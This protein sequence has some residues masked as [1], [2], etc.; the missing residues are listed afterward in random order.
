MEF[1]SILLE[2][3][4]GYDKHYRTIHDVF[5]E[6][7]YPTIQELCQLKGEDEYVY[8]STKHKE[9]HFEYKVGLINM[10]TEHKR[11]RRRIVIKLE[12]DIEKIRDCEG[13]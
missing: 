3:I 11:K 6:L 2:N 1:N 8:I 9:H 10:D 7:L 12:R 13:L 5:D 4:K